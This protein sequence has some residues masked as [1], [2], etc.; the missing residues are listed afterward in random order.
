MARA[1]GLDQFCLCPECMA[2]IMGHIHAPLTE[3]ELEQLGQWVPQV[4]A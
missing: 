2:S 3:D 4:R 1:A